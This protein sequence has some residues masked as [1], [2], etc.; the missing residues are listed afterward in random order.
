MTIT[1]RDEYITN[2]MQ[3]QKIFLT[4]IRKNKSIHS[5]TTILSGSSKAYNTTDSL[6]KL[7]CTD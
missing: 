7:T 2:E 1:K 6:D 4:F 3:L 5:A